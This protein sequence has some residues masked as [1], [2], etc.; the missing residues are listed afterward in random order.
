MLLRLIRKPNGRKKG[1]IL[2]SREATWSPLSYLQRETRCSTD[3]K[4]I[5]AVAHAPTPTVSFKLHAFIYNSM[6]KRS[7]SATKVARTTSSS[8]SC[9]DI[10]KKNAAC[11][12]NH[13]SQNSKFAFALSFS[14]SLFSF[15]VLSL[16]VSSPTNLSSNL[17]SSFTSLCPLPTIFLVRILCILFLSRYSSYRVLSLFPL[18]Y[19]SLPP[20]VLLFILARGERRDDNGKSKGFKR[21]GRRERR[22]KEQ[23]EERK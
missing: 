11:V 3:P 1:A 6:F 2:A 23:R 19:Y 13:K 4:N 22:R 21:G 20:A 15:L 8:C 16:I 7:D 9:M 18:L 12:A 14:L 17:F 5:S 10:V